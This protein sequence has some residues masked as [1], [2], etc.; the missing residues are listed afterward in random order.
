MEKHTNEN[1][2]LNEKMLFSILDVLFRIKLPYT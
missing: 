2:T 1:K